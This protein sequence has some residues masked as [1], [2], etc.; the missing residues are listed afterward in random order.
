MEA[1]LERSED[2]EGLGRRKCEDC[3]IRIRSSVGDDIDRT[4]EGKKRWQINGDVARTSSYGVVIVST[5]FSFMRTLSLPFS[6]PFPFPLS[7]P[8]PLRLFFSFLR[9]ISFST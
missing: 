9:M 1:H 4:I 3:G 8:Y 2:V 5:I 6:F 7:F